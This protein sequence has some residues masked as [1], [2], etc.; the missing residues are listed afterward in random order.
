MG[1]TLSWYISG[2]VLYLKLKGQPKVQELKAINQEIVDILDSSQEKMSIVIDV[3]ELRVSYTS[4]DQLRATQTYMDREQLVLALIVTDNKLNRLITLMA[5]STTRTK[6]IQCKN[7][8][9]VE[10]HLK[11]RGF[12]RELQI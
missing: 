12:V 6:F 5:F 10:I 8:Q 7:L 2:Q 3:N 1:Y 11:N 9:E 4:T